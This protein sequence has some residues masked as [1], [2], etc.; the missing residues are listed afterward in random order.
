MIYGLPKDNLV[1]PISYV[2]LRNTHHARRNT[3]MAPEI[4]YPETLLRIDYV[5]EG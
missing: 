4:V 1:L 2:V 3:K 5:K